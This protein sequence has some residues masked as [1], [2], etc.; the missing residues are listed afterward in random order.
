MVPGASKELEI[1][2]GVEASSPW[3]RDVN[4]ATGGACG[5]DMARSMTS[6]SSAFGDLGVRQV[7]LHRREEASLPWARKDAYKVALVIEGGGMRGAYTSGMVDALERLGLRYSFDVVYGASAG[8]FSAVVFAAGAALGSEAVYGQHLS[9]R[10]FIDFSR[11]IS[12]SESPMNLR[13]LVDKVLTTDLPIDF[14]ALNDNPIAVHLVATLTDSFAAHA[15]DQPGAL[16]DWK[17]ALCASACVPFLAGAPVTVHG[18]EWI[19]GSISEPL[20]VWRAIDAG[21]THVLALLSRAPSE[22]A[23]PI[24]LF[25]RRV[26]NALDRHYPGLGDVLKDWPKMYA[27][28]L[29]LFDRGQGDE[30][31][32]SHLLALRPSVACGVR[33]TTTSAYKLRRAAW[34]GMQAVYNLFSTDNCYSFWNATPEWPR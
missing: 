26:L 34:S 10:Q 29:S 24:V 6:L 7:V 5:L 22:S 28:S 11:L 32:C 14:D 30:R 27:E 13:Y 15:L 3:H 23:I 21:A 1:G 25:R 20:A 19:D 8:A 31:G 9:G 16:T 18:R 33:S 4:I 12:G 2:D 17:S